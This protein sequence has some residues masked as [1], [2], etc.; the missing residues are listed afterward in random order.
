MA[1]AALDFGPGPR[2]ASHAFQRI[3]KKL[4]VCLKW[5]YRLPGTPLDVLKEQQ[6]KHKGCDWVF[7]NARGERL[8]YDQAHGPFLAACKRAK[9]SFATP[10]GTRQP[11]W[12]DL[13]RTFARWA[14]RKGV[15]D[16]TIMEIAGWK[17]HAMLLRYLGAA[18]ADEQRAAFAKLDAD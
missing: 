15:A 4:E 14:R 16:E 7:P 13:R 10:D 2:R 1:R 12:H 5:R 8:T 11:G 3:N 6:K 9:V 17:T 18:K